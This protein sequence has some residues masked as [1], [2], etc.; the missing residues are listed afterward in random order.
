MFRLYFVVL[1][2]ERNWPAQN[3]RRGSTAAGQD[4]TNRSSGFDAPRKIG[5]QVYNQLDGL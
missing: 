5:R 4:L 3:L 1:L 2:L